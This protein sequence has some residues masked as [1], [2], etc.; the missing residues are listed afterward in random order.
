MGICLVVGDICGT[1]GDKERDAVGKHMERIRDQAKTVAVHS[2][3]KFHEHE[4]QV[5]CH[6]D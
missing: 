4:K 3:T 6:E 2:V 1:K 5:D